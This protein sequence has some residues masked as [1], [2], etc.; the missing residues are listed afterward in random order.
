[1]NQREGGTEVEKHA[2]LLVV[3]LKAMQPEAGSPMRLTGSWDNGYFPLP[4]DGA[5][6]LQFLGQKGGIE[7]KR[8]WCDTI[9]DDKVQWFNPS[10]PAAHNAADTWGGIVV[11]GSEV[12]KLRIDDAWMKLGPS[13]EAHGLDGVGL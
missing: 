3:R 5:P 9:E 1:M 2:A 7:G 11:R 12:D 8:D 13:F 4:D 6:Q 10:G